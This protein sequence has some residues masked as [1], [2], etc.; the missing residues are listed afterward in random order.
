MA[1]GEYEVTW[2]QGGPVTFPLG[3]HPSCGGVSEWLFVYPHNTDL[4]LVALSSLRPFVFVFDQTGSAVLLGHVDWV[5]SE[6][7]S[8]LVVLCQVQILV[9]GD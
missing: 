7:V 4:A 5:P 6:C 2:L 9:E 3:F 8:G 1:S